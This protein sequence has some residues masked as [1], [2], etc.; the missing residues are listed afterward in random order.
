MTVG[1]CCSGASSQKFPRRLTPPGGSLQAGDHPIFPR[2]RI[3]LIAKIGLILSC[4]DSKVNP[5]LFSPEKFSGGQIFPSAH[6]GAAVCA[7]CRPARLRRFGLR[8]GSAPA[9]I[10]KVCIIRNSF[11]WCCLI[12]KSPEN[13]RQIWQIIKT[14]SR[15]CF[16]LCFHIPSVYVAVFPV[17]VAVFVAVKMQ[18]R[19][20]KSAK[21]TEA[22]I[23]KGRRPLWGWRPLLYAFFSS[24]GGG[25]KASQ[26][27]EAARL[28]AAWFVWV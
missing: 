12:L 16:V 10:C 15:F 18:A 5:L 4:C 20:D 26:T 27:S 11:F 22:S 9:R 8:Q 25:C 19:R 1:F 13:F 28:A 14:Y 24:P 3:W 6:S 21:S 7:L 17:D 2:Q 23:Q